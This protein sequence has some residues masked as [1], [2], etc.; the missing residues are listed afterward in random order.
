MSMDIEK[1]KKLQ[2]KL[3]Q[4]HVKETY[5]ELP[6]A[7]IQF[8]KSEIVN[9][10]LHKVKITAKSKQ[11]PRVLNSWINSDIL[12]VEEGDK[13]K[14]RRFDKL[15]SI[16][17]NIVIEARK[18]GIPLDSLK[19]T[20]RDLM[21]S[22]IEGF[23]LLKFSVL[24]AI[25]RNPKILMIYEEGHTNIMSLE[26]Y[27]KIFTTATLPT[28][29][30]L[31]LLDFIEPEFPNNAFQRD[32]AIENVYES[33]EKMTLLYFLKT[34]DFKFIKLYIDEKESDVRLI[35]N[36][37]L[38]FQ[39]KDLFTAISLWSFKKVE[40]YLVDDIKLTITT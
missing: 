10:H 29:I 8:L 33:E 21:V 2:D 11:S 38:V 32:F 12:F 24:D 3:N 25:L 22:P 37:N 9:Y 27:S 35:E 14:N 30:N 13:G 19:Q 40:I 39:N 23:S 4:Q 1:L 15:E 36:S 16:W 6:D 18:F 28:H 20:R 31:R 7:F 17:L 5:D 26:A 34:G